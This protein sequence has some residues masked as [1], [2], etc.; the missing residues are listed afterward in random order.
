MPPPQTRPGVDPAFY[1]VGPGSGQGIALTTHLHLVPKLK[2]EHSY[3]AITPMGLHGLL[4][5]E[6]YLYKRILTFL[7]VL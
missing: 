7:N 3:T 2:K 5:G 4:Y 1:M 6:V